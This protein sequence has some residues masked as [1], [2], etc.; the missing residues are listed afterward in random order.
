MDKDKKNFFFKNN[1]WYFIGLAILAF[2]II[3]NL[4]PGGFIIAGEDTTQLIN[5]KENFGNIFYDWQGRAS[6]FYSLFYFLDKIGISST[7]Q[8]SWYL[9]IFIVGS[10]ISFDLFTR[11]IFKKVN[12]LNRFLIS[13]FY[14]LNL[15][16]LYIFTYS[17][18]YSYYQSL[19]IFI[20]LLVGLYLRFLKDKKFIFGA[21]FVLAL[22]AGSSG[23]G[24]SAFALS[25]AIVF[26][27]LTCFLLIFR[28]IKLEKELIKKL[29]LLILFSILI[30]SY[31]ILPALIQVPVGVKALATNNILDLAWWLQHSSN[32]IYNTI[33]LIQ[34]DG[35]WYFPQNFPYSNFEY[36]K[37]YFIALSFLPFLSIIFSIA[38]KKNN[39]KLYWPFLS[40]FIILI[41]GTTRVRF[42]FEKINNFIFQLPG[43]NTLRG[44]EK[45]AIFIPFIM[46]VLILFFLIQSRGRKYHKVSVII[47]CFILLLPLPFYTG[48]LQ[49]NMSFIFTG[50]KVKDYQES[51]YSFLVKIPREYYEIRD[52]IN[53]DTEEFKI[54]SLPYNVIGSI[55]WANYPKWKLQGSDVTKYLYN[56]FLIDS[57]QFYFNYWIFAREFNES[58]YDP[59]WIVKLLGMINAKYIIYHKD[60]AENFIDKTKEKIEYL[61]N[62]EVIKKITENDYFI[63]YE[64]QNQYRMPYLFGINENLILPENP[65]V[66][67]GNFAILKDNIT[68]IFPSDKNSQ[69]RIVVSLNKKEKTNY[70]VLNEPYDPNWRAFYVDNE[71]GGHQLLQVKSLNYANGWIIDK[72]MKSGKVI[73]EYW[74]IRLLYIGIGLSLLSLVVIIIF[75][76]IYY[77]KFGKNEFK[78]VDE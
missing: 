29:P 44:Y 67:N 37:N 64:I 33:R 11:L 52:I 77:L 26:F 72:E 12:Q 48:K 17:W 73:I 20:P 43:F 28:F 47:I 68:Q 40:I 18:G 13:L 60:V 22:L 36:L 16:T 76:I 42:P 69:K 7:G 31:W 32:P 27:L 4:F 25:S 57:N 23:F 6:I 15:Y 5:A 62:Q 56:K 63:L 14:A 54:A 35:Q 3:Q 75:M 71:E 61:E 58:N 50:E 39:K 53:N 51:E 38:Q 59:I 41:A 2:V 46:A 21:W 45:F 30:N 8:L 55:G 9:G 1:Y 65:K 10:Y 24:N 70:L 49:Q 78:R 34:G 74:P 19:Y 66:I